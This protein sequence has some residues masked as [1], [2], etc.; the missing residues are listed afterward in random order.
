MSSPGHA[1]LTLNLGSQSIELAEFRTQP[2]G[3]L[4][5]CGYRSREIL[6][7]P[8]REA[9]RPTQTVAAVREMMG[10]L[11]IKGGPVNYTVAEESVFTRF[12]KLPPIDEEK[13][14]RIISFEAQQN[15]P[16]PIDEVVW[17][18]Q[19]VGGGAGEQIQV[20]LVAIKA[21]LLEEINGAVEETGLRTSIVDLATM[22]LYNAFRHNYSELS[23]CSLLVDIGARTTNLLFIEPGKIFTRS[24]P[25]G[26][27]S[28][29][30]AIAKEFNEP[31]AAAEFRK[32]RD[33]FAV[34]AGACAEP[35]DGDVARVSRIVRSTMTRLHAE[36]MRS[37]SHYC[38]QQQ[39][40]PPER[41]FLSGGGASTPCHPGVFPREIAAADRIF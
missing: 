23:G 40:K 4:I 25:I 36:L 26:G 8:T 15:V 38:A 24:V 9:T 12:V 19:L 17:D 30:S 6:A 31:F 21:D 2:Q 28:V 5:L 29:T 32:K 33:G 39:G 7:D 22:A 1:S 18:Y 34:S 20:I 16:F 35:P 10:E 37:I 13:I 27:S 11:Q 3:G 41:V 14:E